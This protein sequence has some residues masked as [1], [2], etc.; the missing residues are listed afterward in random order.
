[1]S[2]APDADAAR[3]SARRAFIRD[4]HPDA[5]GDPQHFVDGLAAFAAAPAA[6]LAEAGAQAAGATV[7][8]AE[9]TAYRSRRV[10]R[11]LLRSVRAARRR[12]EGRPPRRLS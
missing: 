4:H 1:M 7:R 9:V 8:A 12:L 2:D 5:G 6:H 10:G 11:V 3:R